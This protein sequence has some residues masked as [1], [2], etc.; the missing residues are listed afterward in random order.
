[1]VSAQN[2]PLEVSITIGVENIDTWCWG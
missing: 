2:C 1:M